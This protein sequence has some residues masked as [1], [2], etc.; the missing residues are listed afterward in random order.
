V[1]RSDFDLSLA[2]LS[3]GEVAAFVDSAF[4]RLSSNRIRDHKDNNAEAEKS[5]ANPAETQG[6]AIA[7]VEN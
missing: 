7:A 1:L 4:A 2:S 3:H 6:A 5:R